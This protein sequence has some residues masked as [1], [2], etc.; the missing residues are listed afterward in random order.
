M[1]QFELNRAGSG[2]TG[3]TGAEHIPNQGWNMPQE[4]AGQLPVQVQVN[5]QNEGWST[6]NGHIESSLADQAKLWN[7]SPVVSMPTTNVMTG[8]N[9]SVEDPNSGI[10]TGTE[11]DQLLQNAQLNA[12]QAMLNE[13]QQLHQLQLLQVMME[14]FWT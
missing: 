11:G 6:L 9:R 1:P 14:N 4:N 3:Q 2:W 10:K 12:T 13:Y 8:L 7:R 5:G